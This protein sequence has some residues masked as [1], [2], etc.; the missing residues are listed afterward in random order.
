LPNQD[1]AGATPIFLV[2]PLGGTSFTYRAL[3]EELGSDQP[4]YAFRA[5]GL[6]P[7]ETPYDNVTEMTARYVTKLLAR[8]AVGPHII[9]GHSS[10]GVIAYEIARQLIDRGLE[11]PLLIFIDTVS[12]R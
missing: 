10:G 3:A 12:R 7:G 4:A 8:Q 6:E 9:G 11:P 1:S 2:Q 5:A